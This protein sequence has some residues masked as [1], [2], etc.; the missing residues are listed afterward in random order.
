MPLGL[1]KPR[2]LAPR[3]DATALRWSLP[4]AGRL[5]L[6]GLLAC[7]GG[8]L[9]LSWPAAATHHADLERRIRTL[10]S[11]GS[12]GE[13]VVPSSP[14]KDTTLAANIASEMRNRALDFSWFQL[15]LP[16]PDGSAMSFRAGS[17]RH[18]RARHSR[19]RRPSPPALPGIHKRR[20]WIFIDRELE[21]S[22]ISSVGR[23]RLWCDPRRVDEEALETLELLLPQFVRLRRSRSQLDRAG[24]HRLTDRHR[25]A[26]RAH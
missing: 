4:P 26:Q 15:E 13:R 7:L 12:A 16:E 19:C 22:T 23:L 3:L 21:R 11:V 6:P 25:R 1:P 2:S 24:P 5:T 8:S 17:R 18:R 20:Q 10:R 14:T 9:D